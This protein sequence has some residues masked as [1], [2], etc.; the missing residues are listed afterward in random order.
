MELASFVMYQ[1]QS[2]KDLF[3]GAVNVKEV[4]IEGGI[5]GSVKVGFGGPVAARHEP[6]VRAGQGVGGVDGALGTVDDVV[7]G[8]SVSPDLAVQLG[9]RGGHVSDELKVT[10]PSLEK[11]RQDET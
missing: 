6:M 1:F 3:D 9:G 11:P 2:E 8:G 10:F 7:D 4:G 5:G